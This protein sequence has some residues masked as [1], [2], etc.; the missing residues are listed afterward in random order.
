MDTAE[1]PETKSIGTGLGMSRSVQR[2]PR[3]PMTIPVAKRI[4]LYGFEE[5]RRLLSL[6]TGKARNC[7]HSQLV[8]SRSR[9]VFGTTF[10]GNW[11]WTEI[12]SAMTGRG[13][14]ERQ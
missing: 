8:G 3:A 14:D 9:S 4:H 2:W 13:G 6:L 11:A 7:F 12:S 5:N 1:R 10:F